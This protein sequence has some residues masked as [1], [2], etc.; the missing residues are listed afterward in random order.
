MFH[1]SCC[2]CDPK[3]FEKDVFEWKNLTTLGASVVGCSY[4]SEG[5]CDQSN[6]VFSRKTNI[7]NHQNPPSVGHQSTNRPKDMVKSSLPK[8][9]PL[10]GSM[11]LRVHHV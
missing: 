11:L 3:V 10:L 4:T 8:N 6:S 7:A 9:R 5:A 2:T 1:L